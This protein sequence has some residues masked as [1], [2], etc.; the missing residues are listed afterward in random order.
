V[1]LMLILAAFL[2]RY[3]VQYKTYY[4]YYSHVL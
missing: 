2:T 4:Y 3:A 1:V